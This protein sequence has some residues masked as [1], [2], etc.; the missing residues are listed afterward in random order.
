ML[1]KIYP[2]IKGTKAE[3]TALVPF[4]PSKTL[5]LLV[6]KCNTGFDRQTDGVC[7]TGAK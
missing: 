5:A 1:I 3:L 7:E 2:S 6:A 4:Q